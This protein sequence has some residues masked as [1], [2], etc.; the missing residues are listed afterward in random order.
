MPGAKVEDNTMLT[1]EMGTNGFDKD[2]KRASEAGK[3]SSRGPSLSTIV[4]DI[5][6]AEASTDEEVQALLTRYKVPPK[7]RTLK[8]ALFLAQAEK[9]MIGDT[10]AARFLIESEYG[11]PKQGVEI[12]GADGGP[13][14]FIWPKIVD[15]DNSTS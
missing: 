2:P 1:P 5:L 8:R 7:E 15:A 13:V 6:A 9:A 12:T 4:N 3:K 10:Q 14:E 11:K